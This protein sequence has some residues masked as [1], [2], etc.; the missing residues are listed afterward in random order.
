M[1]YLLDKKV[2]KNKY[3]KYALFV[4]VFLFLMS[5]GVFRGFSYV[6]H[7]VFRPV[8]VLG[9]SVGGKF[10]N[11][12][13]YFSSKKSLLA[14]NAELKEKLYEQE[15]RLTNYNSLLEENIKIKEILG[16]KISSGLSEKGMI[17]SAI[18]SKPNQSPYDTLVIDTGSKEGVLVDQRVFA[19]GDIPIGRVKEV[20][21]RSAKVVLFSSPGEKTNVSV[22][23]SLPGNKDIISSDEN[24]KT[25]DTFM[26]AVGRGGG[27]FEMILPRDFIL[28]K[29][30]EVVLPDISPLVLGIVE[31]I[32]T[33]PRDSFQKALLVSPVNIQEIKFVQ[34]ER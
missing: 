17:L 31:T 29:G 10:S 16:R 12:S 30:T 22:P 33:D 28:K 25:S 34:I 26:E 1:S 13:S 19:F 20:Y 23:L 6:G 27:N 4:A 32:I 24:N 5:L 18:L 2:K 15:A 8:L 14:E 3:L 21:Y 11:I 7:F 9:H